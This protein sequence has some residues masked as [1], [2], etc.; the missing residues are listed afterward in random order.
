MTNLPS[1]NDLSI[2]QWNCRGVFNKREVLADHLDSF[3]IFAF[4]ETWLTPERKLFFK[5]H[6]ILRRDGISNHSGGVL[7]SLRKNIAF[8]K[9]DSIPSFPGILE[10]ISVEVPATPKPLIFVSIYKHPG[11]IDPL[12]WEAFF[13]SFHNLS[14]AHITITGDFNAHHTLWGSHHSDKSGKLLLESSQEHHFFPINDGTPT[15]LTHPSNL[16]SVIDLTFVS[17]H[18]TPLVSWQSFEDALGSDHIPSI[19]RINLSVKKISTFSHK[20]S[21]SGLDWKKYQS[22]LISLAPDLLPQLQ[23][24][25]ITHLDKYEIL[26]NLFKNTVLSLITSKKSNHSQTNSHSKRNPSSLKRTPPPAPWWNDTCSEAVLQRKQ[27][28][29]LFKK[30]P[31]QNNYFNLKRQEASTRKTLRSEKRKSWRSF[32]KD[33]TS[34]TNLNTLWKLIKSYKNRYLGS[35]PSPSPSTNHEMPIGMHNFISAL[36]PASCVAPPP[37][38]T[39]Y[40]NFRPQASVVDSPFTITELHYA[41]NSMGKKKTS[42]GLDQITY[43]IICHTPEVYLPAF[44][45][46]LNEIFSSD[47]LPDSWNRS[48]VFLLPKPVPGKYRPISLTSCVLKTL[49]KLILMRLDWWLERYNKL[50]NS[51]Y[52][53]RK[54]RSCLDNLSILTSEI[55]ISFLRGGVTACL[56]LDLTSAFDDVIP[57]ILFEDLIQMGLPINLCKFIYNLIHLRTIQFSI[58]GEISK[59]YYTSKGVPQG[60][61]LSP[62]LFNIYVAKLKSHIGED[63]EI[64]QFAD[65]IAIFSSSVNIGKALS[66]L[67]ISANKAFKFLSLKGLSVSPSKSSLILFTRKRINPLAYTITLNN[68]TIHSSSS[69]RFLGIILDYKLSG[70]EHVSYIHKRCS[71]LLNAISSLRGTW[72]GGEPRTLLCIYKGLIR[73]SMEYGCA[74]FPYNNFSLMSKLNSIQYKALRICLGLRRTTPTNVIL[75]EASEGPL[76]ERFKLLTA[77]YIF[78]IFS[79]YSHAA[80][81]KLSELYWYSTRKKR[82]KDPDQSFLLFYTFRQ[83]FK[84]KRYIADFDYPSPYSVSFESLMYTPDIFFTSS[85]QVNEIKNSAFPTL[86]FL[87]I[88]GEF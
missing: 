11:P 78:K 36:C 70:K 82:K 6:H 64:I 68:S 43:S 74:F 22:T 19:I 8:R 27:A 59:D 17:S 81:D 44:L 79:L 40:D 7:I 18:T 33:I 87:N 77:R 80:L 84:Y 65:D 47:I 58:N 76:T 20:L 86:T 9:I 60:S 13:S 71:N 56:F 42:P 14:S 31:S 41:L 24:P 46:I 38:F 37:D 12:L 57:N 83:M 16:P 52:G 34:F 66:N 62:T 15:R 23:D 39:L 53:F 28:F 3:D 54:S 5:N 49:E 26:I 21:L 4:S 25:D 29:H 45:D 63:C 30:F 1:L 10:T 32:C 51:Q 48:L 75:A 35:T 67:E 61:I 85:K 50:P 88:Q 73:G 55:H 72:W 2:F 69:C